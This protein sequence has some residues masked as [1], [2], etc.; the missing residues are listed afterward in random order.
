MSILLAIV[1]IAIIAWVA[2]L[3]IDAN[4]DDKKDD[5]NNDPVAQLSQYDRDTLNQAKQLKRVDYDLDGVVNSLDPNDDKDT[6]RDDVDTDD[7]NDNIA[8]SQDDDHDNDNV[9]NDVDN[10][11]AQQT[12]LQRNN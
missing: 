10:E 4:R 3:I 11:A 1:V 7:D 12:E 5:K 9:K 2:W 8:D 6:Q